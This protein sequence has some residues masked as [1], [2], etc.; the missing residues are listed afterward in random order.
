MGR[1]SKTSTTNSDDGTSTGDTV[2][3]LISLLMKMIVEDKL[4]GN[5][6]TGN[7]PETFGKLQ[8][9]IKLNLSCN[10]L[11]GTIPSCI[12]R[13]SKLSILHLESNKFSGSISDNIG[14][15]ANLRE[16]DISNNLLS[17]NIPKSIQALL[18]YSDAS[19]C[20]CFY[21]G[22][23]DLNPLPIQKKQQTF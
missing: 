4:H 7:I 3:G 21:G 20:I 17:G 5:N 14:R 16:I 22:N 13:I 8:N 19:K 11:S 18:S 10:Q 15:L 6:L 12:G 23:R 1:G 9:L 2:Q